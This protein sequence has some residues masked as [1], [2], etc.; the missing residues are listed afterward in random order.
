M[1]DLLRQAL[2]LLTVLILLTGLVY[3][4]A[5]TGISQTVFPSQASG[6]LIVK[7]GRTVGSA[8]IGQPFDAPGYFWG[9]PSATPGWAYNAAASSGSNL[10]QA[11][12]ILHQRVKFHLNLLR[13][14][15]PDSDL[16]V[17][18]DLVTA[19]GSGLDPHI[20]PEAAVFQVRRIARE[21]HLEEARLMA[22]IESKIEGR[23]F[24]LMG[25]PRVNVLQ[26]NLVLDDLQ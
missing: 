10:G 11:N 16:P 12:P 4:L 6:S 20:S 21:R 9:R 5:V 14:N 18:I 13:T 24:G 8:L 23:T 22:L 15:N 2:G 19:S 25:E 17:P 7:E 3:P 26:L 1:V